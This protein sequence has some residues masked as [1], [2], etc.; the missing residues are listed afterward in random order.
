MKFSRGHVGVCGG[1]GGGGGGGKYDGGKG[2]DDGIGKTKGKKGPSL[3][4]SLFF[5]EDFSSIT[6]SLPAVAASSARSAI[7]KIISCTILLQFD[8]A[9]FLADDLPLGEEIAYRAER[10]KGALQRFRRF[11]GEDGKAD[12]RKPVIGSV[13]KRR[14]GIGVR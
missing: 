11:P 2:K 6:P 4:S 3:I 9:A 7:L 14:H 10:T 13:R 1:G 12:F 8:F 5:F